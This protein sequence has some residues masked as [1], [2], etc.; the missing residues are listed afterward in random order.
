MCV[1]A[2]STYTVEVIQCAKS[3]FADH[4]EKQIPLQTGLT[5][6]VALCLITEKY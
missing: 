6:V 4:L 2:Q 5:E 3:L 1:S